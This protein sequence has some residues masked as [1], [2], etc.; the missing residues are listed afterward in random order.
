MLQFDAADLP[1]DLEPDPDIDEF[2]QLLEEL[3][4]QIDCPAAPAPSA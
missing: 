2:I 4:D 1:S 3:E